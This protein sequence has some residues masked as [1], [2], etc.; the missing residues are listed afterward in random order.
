MTAFRPAP[1]A[2]RPVQPVRDR[3]R[4]AELIIESL[5]DQIARGE[6]PRGSRLPSE[7]E[8]AEHFGVG[9]PT[10]RE[11]I[12]ALASMGL[13]E[14]RHGSGTYV[15]AR[16]GDVVALSL[17]TAVQLEHTT[18]AEIIELLAVLNLRAAELAV[19]NATEEDLHLLA[20]GRDTIL[21]G[22]DRDEILHGVQTFLRALAGSAHQPLLSMISE[23]LIRVLVEVEL[24]LFP[25]SVEMWR[26]WT[27]S[28]ADV[29]AEIVEA[30]RLRDGPRL[31]QAVRAYHEN[32][33][34]RPAN[35]P[36]Y[37]M[38]LSDERLAGVMARI[39]SRI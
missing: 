33:T 1:A 10:A 31:Q 30:L 24:E 22:H 4:A 5:R 27:G 18:V 26:E 13:V 15:T 34:S 9:A 21:N 28:L 37:A 17:A 7:R 12:R 29:R 11:A 25:E 20:T 6:L 19:R 8:I 16:P 3:A 36:D 35:D 38:K 39:G 23:F 14:A 2:L 32:A